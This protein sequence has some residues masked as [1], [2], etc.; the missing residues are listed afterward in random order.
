MPKIHVTTFVKSPPNRV[1]DLC[2]HLSLIKKSVQGKN[3]SVRS[4][5]GSP[6]INNGDTITYH[7]K[8]LG[9]HRSVVLRVTEFDRGVKLTEEE[10]KG[11]LN[12]YRHEH[13]FKQID[14]GTIMIDILE[15][16]MPKDFI[17]RLAGKY[18]LKNYLEK[19]ILNRVQIIK[20][21]AETERWHALLG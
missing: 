2:R 5:S 13:Y 3:E 21:Y 18:F 11:D 7:A 14:N 1:F 17:G 12:K 9:K 8:H 19:I 16:D 15:Y 10:V 6:L 20:N 4:S